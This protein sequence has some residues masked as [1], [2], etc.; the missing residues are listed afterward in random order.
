[1]LLRKGNGKLKRPTRQCNRDGERKTPMPRFRPWSQYLFS[2]T[3]CIRNFEPSRRQF[4]LHYRNDCFILF[5]SCHYLN[6][7]ACSHP[8]SGKLFSKFLNS[9]W[10]LCQVTKTILF[11]RGFCGLSFIGNET[12]NKI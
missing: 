6:N 4:N 5:P 7:N 9:F 11:F 8:Q 3:I 2:L 1:M 10:L 12:C